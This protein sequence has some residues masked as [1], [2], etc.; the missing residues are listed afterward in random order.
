MAQ[1]VTSVAGSAA[2]TVVTSTFGASPWANLG[3]ALVG[4]TIPVIVFYAPKHRHWRLGLMLVVVAVAFALTY[5][6][7]RAVDA[8]SGEKTFPTRQ[9]VEKVT[10]G[11]ST[12][13]G[14]TTGGGGGGGGAATAAVSPEQVDCT[15]EGC[16]PVRIES[17]GSEQLTITDVDIDGDDGFSFDGCEGRRLD[18]GERCDMEIAFDGSGDAAATLV[19]TGADDVLARVA[20]TGTVEA[21][22]FGT[23]NQQCSEDGTTITFTLTG[24]PGVVTVGD[25]PS[26]VSVGAPLTLTITPG[27]TVDLE[28]DPDPDVDGDES[29]V[30]VACP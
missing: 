19:V 16:A 26:Q 25:P 14:G 30:S 8:A 27:D 23:A 6:G 20:L 29:T 15:A 9:D 13:G 11:G 10:G 17:T 7:V 24:P 18:P 28:V 5:G 12:G 3:A 4:A 21:Q 2:A 22:G 1:I